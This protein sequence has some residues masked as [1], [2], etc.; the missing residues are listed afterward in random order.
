LLALCGRGTT[1]SATYTTNGDLTNHQIIA[2]VQ[3]NTGTI[4][5]GTAQASSNTVFVYNDV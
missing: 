1:C 5:Q 4:P 2:F 3:E